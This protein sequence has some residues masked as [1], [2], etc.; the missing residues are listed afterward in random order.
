MLAVISPP[1]AILVHLPEGLQ[2]SRQR[3][4][5]VAK[6]LQ[7]SGIPVVV[8]DR[9]SP[10]AAGAAAGMLQTSFAASPLNEPEL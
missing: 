8:V 3:F 10:M 4:I 6:R 1:S 7:G 9:S 2:S 5:D